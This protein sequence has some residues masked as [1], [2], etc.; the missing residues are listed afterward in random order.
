LNLRHH[1]VEPGRLIAELEKA[2]KIFF[3][4]FLQFQMANK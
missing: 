1:K 2:P 3:G 4:A